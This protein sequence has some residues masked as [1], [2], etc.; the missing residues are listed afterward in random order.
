MV[1]KLGLPNYSTTHYHKLVLLM[2]R[3]HMLTTTR[4]GANCCEMPTARPSSTVP[5]LFMPVDRRCTD[6][7]TSRHHRAT[8]RAGCALATPC[9]SSNRVVSVNYQPRR[10]GIVGN[11][12]LSERSRGGES[13]RGALSSGGAG[14]TGIRDSTVRQRLN[15]TDRNCGIS[16]VA[17]SRP[18]RNFSTCAA[19]R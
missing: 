16:S 1:P 8:I 2:G 13:K 3:C 7:A 17:D 6:A 4:H 10:Y 11:D 18:L 15:L 14:K 19:L 9:P 5:S 12:Y